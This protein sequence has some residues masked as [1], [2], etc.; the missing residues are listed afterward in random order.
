[1]MTLTDAMTELG[2]DDG[3]SADDARRAYLRLLKTRKPDVD[4]QGFQ[5]LRAAYELVKAGG[6]NQPHAPASPVPAAPFDVAMHPVEPDATS[7]RDDSTPDATSPR[8]DSALVPVA[9]PPEA[10]TD[11]VAEAVR[12]LE[13]RAD[14]GDWTGVASVLPELYEA[15]LR[16]D[17]PLEFV[18]PATVRAMLALQESMNLPASLALGTAFQRFLDASGAERRVLRGNLLYAWALLRELDSLPAEFPRSVRRVI[19]RAIERGD[20]E[21]ARPEL[22]AYRK[23]NKRE[24]ADVVLMLHGKFPLLTRSFVPPLQ[25][26]SA[27]ERGWKLS[28][29]VILLIIVG[30]ALLAAIP[31]PDVLPFQKRTTIE[32]RLKNLDAAL[33][34]GDCSWA[35][36]ALDNAQK[37]LRDAG[38]SA[39]PELRDRVG[40][41]SA[42]YT[43]TCG[44]GTGR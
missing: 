37:A 10:V 36:D 20:L 14:R 27:L 38:S 40:A 19:A 35:R 42:R 34:K 30:R 4:P 12:K 24:A 29:P 11:A 15:A 28:I 41:A 26:R 18:G 8:D 44:T 31:N 39:T 3:A 1:M 32:K 43:R 7:P 2:I 23:T 22:D 6:R 21:S 25:G 13:A 9:S 17:V 5:R 33:D 16:G